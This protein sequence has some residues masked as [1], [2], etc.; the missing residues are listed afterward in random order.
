V[1]DTP[2]VRTPDFRGPSKIFY[3]GVPLAAIVLAL[4]VAELGLR[5]FHPIPYSLEQNMV[6]EAD[7]DTGFRLEPGGV[8]TFANG[9]RAAANSQGLRNREVGPKPRGSFRIL[10]LGDSLTV[11]AG[12]EQDEAYP[13]VLERILARRVSRPIEVVNAGVG[14]W[15][16]FQYAQYFAREGL[17]FEPDLVLVGFSIAGNDTYGTLL[18]VPQLPTVVHGRRVSR[19]AA[20]RATIDLEVLL[21][22]HSHLA[23][24][25]R[26]PHFPPFHPRRSCD[27]F[28]AGFLAIQRSHLA[29]HLR[30]SAELEAR[31]RPNVEQI[32]RIQRLASLRHVPVVV[33]LLPE[34][35]QTSPALRAR[36]LVGEDPSRYD[37][38]MPQTMLSDLFGETKITVID[39]L[40]AFLEDQ[41]CLFT[42]DTHLTP[43]GNV[44]AAQTI[45]P[46]LLRWISADGP[47]TAHR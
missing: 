10:A 6:F 37:F 17:S 19:E 38:S 20:Q 21:E 23:R 16:P 11:G 1:G 9:A 29:N 4:L 15:D 14:G 42:D 3:F 12:V 36:L 24:A 8:A 13:Q 26:R 33:A 2:P 32:R 39:L 44:L 27:D 22:V 34:E 25:L 30:R 46:A 28:G 47:T 5:I 45:A 35:T 43:A 18:S 31:A 41:R 7:P 40:P